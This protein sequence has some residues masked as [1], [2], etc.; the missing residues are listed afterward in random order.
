MSGSFEWQLA[1]SYNFEYGRLKGE[2]FVGGVYVRHFLK[3]PRFALRDPRRFVEGLMEK[4][5]A[6]LTGEWTGLQA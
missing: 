6:V 2:L 1:G 4:H 3:D 5:V